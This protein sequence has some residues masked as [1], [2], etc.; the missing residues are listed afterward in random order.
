MQGCRAVLSTFL[1]IGNTLPSANRSSSDAVPHIP[2]CKTG[3][4]LLYSLGEG[5]GQVGGGAEH[6]LVLLSAALR[7]P[8]CLREGRAPACPE[9]CQPSSRLCLHTATL[10]LSGGAPGR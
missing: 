2:T 8:G 1:Q 9:R 7:W 4:L 10:M 5:K 3:L 6:R